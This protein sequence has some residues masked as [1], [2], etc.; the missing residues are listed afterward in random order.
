[1]LDTPHEEVVRV[2]ICHDGNQW[3]GIEALTQDEQE[4]IEHEQD[5]DAD[6][7]SLVEQQEQER[8]GKSTFWTCRVTPPV[9]NGPANKI[10]VI[11]TRPQ[12]THL[13]NH[14]AGFPMGGLVADDISA[15]VQVRDDSSHQG[16]MA[17][18]CRNKGSL[19]GVGQ[20]ITVIKALRQ[21]GDVSD[22]TRS[23]DF[24]S[25][26]MSYSVKETQPI[27]KDAKV[28]EAGRWRKNS[29]T[30]EPPRRFARKP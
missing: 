1:V 26:Y 18:R 2:W 25:R 16:P 8:A 9:P 21:V 12:G 13:R 3:S 5:Q 11:V 17:V 14:L 20:F 7:Q 15:N 28:L 24:F 6:A 29:C 27:M 22:V 19:Q 4:A 30:S 10:P 23:P